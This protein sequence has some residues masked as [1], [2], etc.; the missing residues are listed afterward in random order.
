MSTLIHLLS[1]KIYS[2]Y[3]PLK[4]LLFKCLTFCTVVLI[5][6]FGLSICKLF[7][8]KTKQKHSWATFKDPNKNLEKMY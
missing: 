8:P 2:F 5:Y 4:D 7:L 6:I 1:L 3:L